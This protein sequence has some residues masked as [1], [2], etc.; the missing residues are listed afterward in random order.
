MR[1][2]D[3]IIVNVLSNY[4]LTLVG[5]IASLVMVPIVI[6]ELRPS[7]YGLAAMLLA[8]FTVT[9][10]LGQSINRALQRYIPQDLASP[11]P[12]QVCITFNS[13]LACHALLGVLAACVIWSLRTWYLDDPDIG[14]ELHADGTL[15]FALV[16]L[17]LIVGAPMLAY[18][19]ALEAIQ[20]FDLVVAHISLGTF[21]RTLAVIVLFKIGYGSVTVFVFSQVLA[22]MGTCLLCRKALRKALPRIHVSVR[23]VQVSSLRVLGR[24]AVG[25][26]LITGGNVLGLEGFR[27]LIGK[28][29]SMEAVGGLSAV[30]AFRTMV[31]LLIRNMTNVLTPAVST[32]D[33]RGATENIGKLLLASTKYAAAAAV[34]ICIVPLVV[35]DQFLQLWLGKEF[36]SLVPLMYTV[37]LAQ[38]PLA[39]STSSQQV[40]IGLGRMRATVPIIFIRGAGGLAVAS[41]YLFTVPDA[42]LVGAAVCLY[43][44]QVLMSMTLFFYGSSVTQIGGLRAVLEGLVRPV[45][46]GLA[47]CVITWLVSSQIGSDKWWNLLTSI[48]GGEVVFLALIM[49]VGLGAEERSRLLGFAGRVRGKLR[50]A[51]SVASSRDHIT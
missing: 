16:C 10:T 22:T 23:M 30:W 2:A 27:V 3:R 34:S 49:L 6:G 19:A 37:M 29:L 51:G 47:A 25:G 40:L 43:A 50:P 1:Q 14:P 35:A 46:L 5:G 45:A 33:A 15:G 38:V 26:L 39:M 36:V 17:S 13:A 9:E 18:R 11:N 42:N 32:M 48:A 28:R 24:F 31:F 20:R 44:V 41:V 7:G 12:D 21:L 8:T 4:G